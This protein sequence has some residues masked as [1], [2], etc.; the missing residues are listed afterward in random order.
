MSR[1][2]YLYVASS[3]RNRH[4]PTVVAMLRGVS[5]A[6]DIEP[7]NG[8]WAVHDFRDEAGYFSWRQ[9]DPDWEA[10][11]RHAYV[12]KVR[13][14]LADVGFNRDMGGLNRA[15]ACL[16]VGPCGRSAHLELGYAAGNGLATAIYLP[17]DQE[18]ELMYR[19]ADDILTEPTDVM[20]WWGQQLGFPLKNVSASVRAGASSREETA[21]AH[22]PSVGV[23]SP[24]APTFP[25]VLR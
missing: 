17:E 20:D 6:A 2:P 11:D 10:W 24:A 15:T 14:P 4:Y 13:H 1:P 25:R 16:L 22:R 7:D 5:A 21:A 18:P 9:I 23:S 19:M 12:A 8:T 3:W